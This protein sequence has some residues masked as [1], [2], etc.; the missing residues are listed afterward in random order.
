MSLHRP[1]ARGQLA[2]VLAL[3]SFTSTGWDGPA[4]PEKPA[5]YVAK[6][7][8]GPEW[9]LTSLP[10]ELE[11]KLPRVDQIRPQTPAP[12]PDDPPPH[13][14]AMFDIPY[15]VEPPDILIVEVLE[16]L[17]GRPITGER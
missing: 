9:R 5:P 3:L 11:A 4:Q 14:G 2:G 8:G 17:P 16:A 10:P 15:V 1:S 7:R 13:E 12:I 6:V